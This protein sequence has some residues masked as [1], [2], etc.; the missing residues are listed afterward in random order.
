M[1]GMFDAE[2]GSEF[3]LSYGRC[4]AMQCAGDYGGLTQTNAEIRLDLLTIGMDDIK[5]SPLPGIWI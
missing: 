5:I 1:L 4:A 3:S 2:M